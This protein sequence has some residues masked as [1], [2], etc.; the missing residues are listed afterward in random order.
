MILGIDPG[1]NKTGFAIVSDGCIFQH[2]TVPGKEAISYAKALHAI[3]HFDRCAIERPRLGGI[4]ARHMTKTNRVMSDAGRVKL[5]MNVGQNVYLSDELK[6]EIERLGVLVKQITPQRKNTKWDAEYWKMVFRWS[7]RAPSE[8]AR[9]ASVIAFQW[10][11]RI[12]Y[13]IEKQ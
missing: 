9:D 5:A 10:E 7:G 8:H 3:Y 4:Y 13:E 2:K 12:R 1:L 11:N 6:T